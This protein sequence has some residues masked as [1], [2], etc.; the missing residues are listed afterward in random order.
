MYSTKKHVSIH[1]IHKKIISI[2]SK[3]WNEKS[4]TNDGMKRNKLR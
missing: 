1:S 4:T 2:M 3:I